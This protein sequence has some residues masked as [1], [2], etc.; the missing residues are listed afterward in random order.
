MDFFGFIR[1]YTGLLLMVFI[2]IGYLFPQMA[3]FKPSLSWLLIIMLFISLLKIDLH[4]HRFLRPGL[5]LYGFFNWL[6]LPVIIMFL[7]QGLS[8][9][10][11][12]GLLIAIITPTALGSPVII[13]LLD[14]DLEFVLTQ[15]ILYNLLAPLSFAF[16][17]LLYFRGAD[18]QIPV[19][20][21]LINVARI[22][23]IPLML[24]LITKKSVKAK[25]FILSKFS[26]FVP[27]MVIF[28]AM[29]VVA[30]ASNQIRE[31]HPQTVVIIFSITL[32]ASAL[33]YL[34]GFI[35]GKGEQKKTLPVA[36]GHK[37]TGLA[38]IVCLNSF[39][40]LVALPSIFYI[41]SHHI[42]NAI[43]LQINARKR[44]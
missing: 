9:E 22:I 28:L 37:N 7:S 11:R 10:Y 34:I 3:I 8:H 42:M 21:I 38:I 26:K 15:V 32:L 30:S 27:L 44:G 6:V 35:I 19:L 39:S 1:K 23:G 40:P 4:F 18:V 43:I 31:T 33:L 29:V 12:I 25:E 17:P 36:L 5:L 13:S 41:I 14:G 2:V 16:L 24:S 20:T